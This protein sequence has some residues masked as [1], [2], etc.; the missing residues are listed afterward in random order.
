MHD[1]L[2]QMYIF[3]AGVLL[4]ILCIYCIYLYLKP[5]I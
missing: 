3:N 1:M 4:N 2:Y 5:E